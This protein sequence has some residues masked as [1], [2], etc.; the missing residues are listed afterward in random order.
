MSRVEGA[1]STPA[2]SRPAPRK[3]ARETSDEQSKRKGAMRPTPPQAYGAPSMWKAAAI[4]N[5]AWGVAAAA[6][7]W[8]HSARP[9]TDAL[10]SRSVPLGD[11]V[12]QLP[13]AVTAVTAVVTAVE[14]GSPPSG[15]QNAAA[16]TATATRRRRVTFG[17]PGG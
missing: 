14:G 9:P 7:A 13:E 1:Q 6:T 10:P 11:V 2:V 4:A 17:D 8:R 3:Y 12:G 16:A 15:R 5:A